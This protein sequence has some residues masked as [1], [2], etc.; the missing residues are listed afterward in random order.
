MI[1]PKTAFKLSIKVSPERFSMSH[2][3]VGTGP[4]RATGLPGLIDGLFLT[5]MTSSEEE[6]HTI[7]FTTQ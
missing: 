5:V 4:H 1:S 7:L 3:P 2:K 6:D